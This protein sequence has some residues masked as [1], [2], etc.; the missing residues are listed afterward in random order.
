MQSPIISTKRR[1]SVKR[2]VLCWVGTIVGITT[3]VLAWSGLMLGDRLVY[4]KQK[5]ASG[6]MT[7]LSGD[8]RHPAHYVPGEVLVKFR[9]EASSSRIKSLNVDMGAKELRAV[10]V[11]TGVIHQYKLEG[12]L[13]V[14]EAV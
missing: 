8:V 13:S 3:A 2:I 10:S 12:A 11:N 6:G 7:A 14:D 4:A 9:D 5:Q 1:S